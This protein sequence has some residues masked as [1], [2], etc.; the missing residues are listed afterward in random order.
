MTPTTSYF[1][2]VT[3]PTT[4]YFSLVTAPTTNCFSLIMDSATDYFSSVTARNTRATWGAAFSV[5]PVR[6]SPASGP[7]PTPAFARGS[8]GMTGGSGGGPTLRSTKLRKP[9]EE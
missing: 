2:L 8:G 1:S 5:V 9:D 6:C 4:S 3:A 7:V